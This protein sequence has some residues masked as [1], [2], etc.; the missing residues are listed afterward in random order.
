MVELVEGQS[1]V[2]W[3]LRSQILKLELEYRR[4]VSRTPGKKK[5]EISKGASITDFLF[6]FKQPLADGSQ[7]IQEASVVQCHL[8]RNMIVEDVRTVIITLTPVVMVDMQTEMDLMSTIWV[9]LQQ[10]LV[11]GLHFRECQCFLLAL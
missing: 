11:S 10:F 5:E 9:S 3:S 8:E 4:K 6:S 1:R 7:L 2:V